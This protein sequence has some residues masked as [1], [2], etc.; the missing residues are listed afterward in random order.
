MRYDLI[1]ILLS[2]VRRGLALSVETTDSVWIMELSSCLYDE[3]K[4]DDVWIHGLSE[5][6]TVHHGR[7]QVDLSA[8]C[9]STSRTIT[10]LIGIRH[11]V[12]VFPN[13]ESTIVVHYT[14]RAPFRPWR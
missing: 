5:D 8:R 7:H 4:L 3:L 14:T 13:S 1:I 10:A 6:P 9:G 12:S 2:E 11:K